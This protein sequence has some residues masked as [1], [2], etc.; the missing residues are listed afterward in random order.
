MAVAVNHFSV[1]FEGHVQGVGFRFTTFQLAKGYEVTGYVKNLDDGRVQLELEGDREECRGLIK[2]LS[3][4]MAGFIRVKNQQ[5][6]TR[7]KEFK[8]FTIQ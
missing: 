4:E 7:E 3:E 8:S 2:A 1:F 5:E 6:D